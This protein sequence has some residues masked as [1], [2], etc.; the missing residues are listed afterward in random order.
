MLKPERERFDVRPYSP[1]IRAQGVQIAGATALRAP[2]DLG[3]IVAVEITFVVSHGA[4]PWNLRSKRNSRQ[5]L[6]GIDLAQL[7]VGD[8]KNPALKSRP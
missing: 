3:D 8:Q 5:K 7:P 1:E 6:H 4:T 2:P